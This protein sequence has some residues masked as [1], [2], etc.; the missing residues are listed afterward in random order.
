M[1]GRR[2]E[3]VRAHLDAQTGTD[4]GAQTDTHT[5]MNGKWVSFLHTL[6]SGAKKV[7]REQ[8]HSPRDCGLSCK[9]RDREKVVLVCARCCWKL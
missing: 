1:K 8:L 2:G 9:E 5:Y 7:V 6:D 4:T 3:D